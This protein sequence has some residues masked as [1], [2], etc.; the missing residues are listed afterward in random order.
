MPITA[1]GE[2]G[3]SATYFTLSNE[4]TKAPD[5]VVLHEDVGPPALWISCVS[6]PFA[7]GLSIGKEF[8]TSKP[9]FKYEPLVRK[10]RQIRYRPF[11]FNILRSGHYTDS[12]LFVPTTSFRRIRC[13][14][15]KY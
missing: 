15:A 1:I 9:N 4:R 2:T 10:I 8:R 6:L 13:G 11:H 7:P 12:Y 5:P 14:N 3:V